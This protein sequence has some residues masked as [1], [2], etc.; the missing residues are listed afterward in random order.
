MLYAYIGI[1][2][3]IRYKKFGKQE[4][5]YEITSYWDPLK[6]KP[7][8]KVKY[9]GVVIDKNEGVFEKRRIRQ[10]EERLIL[11]F[12]DTYILLEFMK[13][14]KLTDTIEIVF[15][16]KAK[17]LLALICYRLSHAGAM[18]YGRI[19]LEGNIC[20]VLLK[21]VNISSQRISDFL[22]YIGDEKLQR[23]FF[24]HYISSL[25]DKGRGVIID[26]TAL[27][28]QIDLGFSRWGYNDGEIDKQIRFLFVI[29]R[30][31][32]LPLYFRYLPGNIVD[33]SSLIITIEELKKFGIEHSFVLID[34]G[35]FS[36][37]SIKSLYSKDIEFLTRLPSSRVLY[38]ELIKESAWD[39]ERFKNARRYGKR[40][41]F[42]KEEGI[43]LYGRKAYAY[44]VLDPER[45]GRETKEF[46]IDVMEEDE[47]EDID[48]VEIE[49]NLM[50][51]GIMILI[52]SFKI[53][54]GDIVPLYY[55]RQTAER[56]F[57][58]SKDDLKLIPL[59]VHKEETLRGYLLFIFIA[60]VV[61]LLLKKGIG[62]K[63]TVEEVLMIMKNLK[64]KVYDDE[65]LI[66]ELS[67]QQREIAEK[68]NILVP[69]KLGI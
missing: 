30:N 62:E 58:F 66:Q 35:F 63:H 2:S 64:C 37:D 11:D 36:E 40:V 51:Q 4:Y 28:N 23:D 54:K 27:P 33:V 41:F 49:Y 25:S 32:S 8:Q 29:D 3:Y 56:L 47:D 48:E 59:R 31:T 60:L 55:L 50:K 69:K 39:L 20:R 26:T 18:N 45:K 43:N 57:G 24:R 67:K 46:L 16:D 12:G 10:K 5:A 22:Q 68:L 7:R 42:I 52:S 34:G 15:G 6:K 17:E 19:W 21:D 38:K 61:F 13:K 44:I 65:I 1:M 9:I 53:E 14:I